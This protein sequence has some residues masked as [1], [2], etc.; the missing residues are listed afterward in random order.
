MALKYILPDNT[1]PKARYIE[2]AREV[3]GN[4][5]DYSESIY[6]G[7]KKPITIYCPKHDYRFTVAMAQNHILKP[8]KTE[9]GKDWSNYLK[10]CKKNSRVGKLIHPKSHKSIEQIEKE[11][12]IRQEKQEKK[13]LEQ[14]NLIQKYNAHDYKE[15]CFL[16]KVFKMYGDLYG[17][18][19]VNYRDREKEVTLICPIH[20]TFD[21]TPRT[22]LNGQKGNKPHGCWECEGIKKPGPSMD[23]DTFFAAMRSLYAKN[24]LDFS[25][26]IFD[27]KGKQVTV[28]CLKHGEQTHS[29]EWWLKGKG[30][31]YCHGKF[32]P[33]D[34]LRLARE[35]HGNK[36]QYKD[37]DKITSKGSII[38]IHCN[39]PN[40]EW[41]K[42][43]VDR[44]LAGDGCR[45]CAKRHQTR[46]QRARTFLTE[47]I[48]KF[49]SER[50]DYGRVMDEY[51][52]NDA[53]IHIRCNEHKYW[54]P[55]T[56]DTHI[57][58]NGG[59]PICNLSRG[60]MEVLLWL[61]RHKIPFQRNWYV[62]CDNPLLRQEY[63]LADFFLLKP[64]NTIIEFNG[65]QHY[66][67][68]AFFRRDKNWSLEMQQ[69]R[70]RT[71][72]VECEKRGWKLLEIKYEQLEHIG[73][74]L[75]KVII[76]Y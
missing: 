61:E 37:V 59:C 3:W 68:V 39:N 22:L 18:S 55:V 17:T 15:A 4:L 47:A 76:H 1:K 54:F 66:E 63:M 56:P 41:H 36:Y 16:E 23:S 20:G 49:G 65:E 29:T 48:A 10:V 33:G 43:R 72:R 30:C 11:K 6:E 9:Y 62:P 27:G 5:Y 24:E 53:H 38:Q 45:E 21:I 58:R 50:F 73:E 42:Q 52:N 40:H 8:H 13:R 51:T 12:R 46:E 57:R 74:I 25:E 26:S 75:Q 69:E 19:L 2:Q 32:Y 60:E 71:M 14:E 67:D 31:E 7:G 44:H 34:F 64:Y 28:K 35:A 70:D